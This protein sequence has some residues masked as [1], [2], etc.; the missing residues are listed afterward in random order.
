MK[1]ALIGGGGIA[2]VHGPLIVNEPDATLVGIA[3]TDMARAKLLAAELNGCAAY[4]DA[5]AMIDAMRPDVVH[6]LVP[7]QYHADVSIMAMDKGCHVLVE[8]PMAMSLAEA[9][10]MIEAAKRN[11]VKLCV[12]HSLLYEDVIRRGR[13][14]AAS[15]AIGEVIS[16]EVSYVYDGKR[17]PALLEPGAQHWYWAYRLN[18]GLLQDLMPHAASVIMEYMPEVEDVHAVSVDR[19]LLPSGW[20]DEVRVLLG[21]Q[22]VTGYV[23]IS[24]NQKP[25]SVKMTLKGDRGSIEAD[26]FD[27]SLVLRRKSGLPRAVDR[28][29][30]GFRIGR[31]YL[32]A[33][34]GNLYSFGRG[35]IDKSQGI[36]PVISQFYETLRRGEDP[37]IPME[38]GLHVVQLIDRVWPEPL[39]KL[40]AETAQ[41]RRPRARKE[42]VDALVTGASGFIGTHLIKKLQAENLTVRALVRRNSVHAGRLKDVDVDVVEGDLA[43]PEVLAKATQGA[44]TV[45][46]AGAT[47][48]SNWKEHE[49]TNVKGTESLIEASLANGVERFVHLSTLAVYALDRARRR[50]TVTETYP[51][52]RDPKKMGP[53]AYSKTE[54]ERMILEA[55]AKHGL[56]A[57]ILRPGIVFGPYGPVFFP[58]LGYR[59][60][61]KFILIGGGTNVL[62]LTYVPNTVD[63]VYRASVE[64]AAVGQIYNVVDDGEITAR[65]YLELFIETTGA[66]SKIISLPYAVPY[67]A[68]AAYEVVSGI[69]LIKKGATSRAQLKTKRAD[70]RMDSSKA[71][72]ELHWQPKIPL[73]Q[74][75]AETFEWYA[76]TY[77][78]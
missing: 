33:S 3:D 56:G 53:Y 24:L 34:F 51:Q 14:L 49:Q 73:E 2:R 7:P 36:G 62:P 41:A 17:N 76:Q 32:S 23:S 8:K 70:V 60:Q 57:T 69:G 40:P 22:G 55:H 54:G 25:D 45:F 61:D 50:A 71:K 78:S 65:R 15:G 58:H 4:T 11:D 18:G 19:G 44:K 38:Q 20:P 37:P 30:S 1:V 47:L 72:S 9:E 64:P 27:N 21:S 13:E 77:M 74:G 48:S 52:H 39:V 5:A 12:N 31:Q 42:A 6:V 66:E 35:R 75:M 46:H 63:A 43:D 28:G 67:L 26:A 29:F 59:Y 10:S 68:T 16:V